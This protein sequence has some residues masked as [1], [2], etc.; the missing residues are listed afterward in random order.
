MVTTLQPPPA[1]ILVGYNARVSTMK[2]L[3]YGTVEARVKQGNA[4][5]VVTAMTLFG[6]NKDEID[7][8]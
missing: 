6:D 2:Y 1:G 8:E 3:L 4:G 5:G 7:F